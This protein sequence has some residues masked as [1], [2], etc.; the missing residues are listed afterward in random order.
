MAST[1]LNDFKYLTTVENSLK[2]I[3]LNRLVLGEFGITYHLND[4]FIIN[5]LS[6]VSMKE[7]LLFQKMVSRNQQLN[8][9]MLD[10]IFP[11]MMAEMATVILIKGPMTGEQYVKSGYS[12]YGEFL[13]EHKLHQFMHHLLYA[14]V[15]DEKPFSG[16]LDYERV[17]Y[18]K[19]QKE[20]IEY[21]PVF[22]QQKLQ[23]LLYN[24]AVIKIDPAKSRRTEK[25]ATLVLL[26]G[27]DV[28]TPIA[29]DGNA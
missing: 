7:Q 17:Y 1:T 22:E 16:N 9:M 27:M 11:L 6:R 13:M 15:A 12:I 23:T 20:E 8:L 3:H 19:G 29:E 21:F 14:D 4:G 24:N 5:D 28:K 10:S 18:R 26:V 2:F 25:E